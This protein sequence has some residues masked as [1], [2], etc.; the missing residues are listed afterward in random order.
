MR[1]CL[2]PSFIS[3]VTLR[4]EATVVRTYFK[5]PRKFYPIDKDVPYPAPKQPAE[6]TRNAERHTLLAMAVAD[7]VFCPDKATRDRFKYAISYIRRK[8]VTGHYRFTLRRFEQGWR[9]WRFPDE[10]QPL[11]VDAV[12][13]AASVE[14]H[15]RSMAHDDE[16]GRPPARKARRVR[17]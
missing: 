14:V 3:H 2:P 8:V 7:S 6:T 13:I 5:R 9:V 10:G 17:P 12:G 1:L 15:S 16:L 4:R 11:L